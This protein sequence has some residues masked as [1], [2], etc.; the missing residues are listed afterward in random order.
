[1]CSLRDMEFTSRIRAFSRSCESNHP[2]NGKVV[3]KLNSTAS[4]GDIQ[5][6]E[7]PVEVSKNT[8]IA[9]LHLAYL[10][11]F[12]SVATDESSGVTYR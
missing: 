10:S 8:D 2:L 5:L 7:G 3:V 1:M 4:S 11:M 9:V 6:S 12:L